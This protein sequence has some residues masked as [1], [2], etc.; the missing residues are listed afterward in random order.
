LFGFFAALV[1]LGC[2]LFGLWFVLG[3]LPDVGAAF[4]LAGIALFAIG[5]RRHAA[6]GLGPGDL[7][8]HA[9]VILTVSDA[10]GEEILHPFRLAVVGP[11][12]AAGGLPATAR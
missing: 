4:A 9:K 1:P 2:A 7:R 11:P 5:I 12:A 8:G 3:V 10:A 6:D